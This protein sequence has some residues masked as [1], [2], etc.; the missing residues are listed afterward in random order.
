M[1]SPAHPLPPPLAGGGHEQPL[2]GATGPARPRGGGGS[3]RD[4]VHPHCPRAPRTR[5]LPRGP[6]SPP[7][8]GLFSPAGDA[9]P[10]PLLPAKCY[11]PSCSF[12]PPQTS[13]HGLGDPT[14]AGPPTPGPSGWQ[15][16]RDRG[17][18]TAVS[19]GAPC[20][21]RGHPLGRGGRNGPGPPPRSLPAG[22]VTRLS[23]F[24]QHFSKTWARGFFSDTD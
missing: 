10:N 9:P 24:Q 23:G 18:L 11:C 20:Q 7:R 14:A 12:A 4:L 6:A 2:P 3:S 19:R 17:S 1:E 22:D 8:R 13:Q 15:V 16:C 5:P 21:L